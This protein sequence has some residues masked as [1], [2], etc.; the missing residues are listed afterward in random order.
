MRQYAA[1]SLASV[2][3][4]AGRPIPQHMDARLFTSEAAFLAGL[5]SR[6]LEAKRL[7]GGVKDRVHWV[8]GLPDLTPAHSA[9]DVLLHPTIYD[10]FGLVVAESMACGTPAIVSH[11]AGVAEFVDHRESGWIVAPDDAKQCAEALTTLRE[12]S[13]LRETM[14]RKARAIAATRNWDHVA[15]ETLA[16][17]QHALSNK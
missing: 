4:P 16:C 5:K 17:Y 6:T 7:R 12:N 1:N 11:A 8:G 2:E 9:A 15:E 10:A 14:A 3:Q 13:T